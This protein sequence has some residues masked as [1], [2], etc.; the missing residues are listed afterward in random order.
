MEP[1]NGG[2][3][4]T[5]DKEDVLTVRREISSTLGRKTAR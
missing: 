3:E 5:E 2:R 4:R 1:I